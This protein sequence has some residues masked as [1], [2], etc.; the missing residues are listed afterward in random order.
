MASVASNR[1]AGSARTPSTSFAPHQPAIH[2][3]AVVPAIG[4]RRVAD[5][6]TP[7]L[8]CRWCAITWVLQTEWRLP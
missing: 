1:Q 4:Q 2:R 6:M 8:L 5:A 7:D 3:P